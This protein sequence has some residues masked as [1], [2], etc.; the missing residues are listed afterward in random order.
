MST[1]NK[2]E[3]KTAS[4]PLAPG[5]FVDA[6]AEGTKFLYKTDAFERSEKVSNVRYRMAYALLRGGEHFHGQSKIFFDLNEAGK[7]S[8]KIFLDYKGDK[9]LS[10]KINGQHITEGTPFRE[11]R[12]YLDQ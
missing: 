8:D 6:Q 11:H 4:E 12:I 1:E 5:V 3:A 10:L 9:L 2:E 7:A